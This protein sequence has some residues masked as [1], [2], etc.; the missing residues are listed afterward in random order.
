MANT[1][2]LQIAGTTDIETITFDNQEVDK[3]VYNGVTVWESG[4]SSQNPQL[5]D[6]KAVLAL[7]DPASVY[8][9]GTKIP[10]TYNGHSSPLIVAQYL[11][12]SNNSAYGG[13]EGVILIREFVEPTAKTAFAIGDNAYYE[14]YAGTTMKTFLDTTYYDN[15][16]DELKSL[17]SEIS[18]PCYRVAQWPDSFS[19]YMES[20][21]CTWF[22][23]SA[24]EV[25]NKGA[26]GEAGYEGVIWDYWKERTGLSSPDNMHEA[27]SGRIVRDVDGNSYSVTLRSMDSGTGVCCISGPYVSGYEGAINSTGLSTVDPVFPACF[28]AKN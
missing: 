7:D 28:V 27:N 22:S 19:P 2:N 25:C 9:I 8:P 3:V 26:Y 16:S 24:Y 13:A 15:C 6:L 1:R 18:I 10:D 14:G 21:S 4:P 17:I 23:M 5:S 20:V 11:N 12:S